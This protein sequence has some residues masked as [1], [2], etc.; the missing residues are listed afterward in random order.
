MRIEAKGDVLLLLA[1]HAM[2]QDT[3]QRASPHDLAHQAARQRPSPYVVTRSGHACGS[4]TASLCIT[5][6]ASRRSSSGNNGRLFINTEL[7]TTAPGAQILVDRWHW[8]YN[9]H[10]LRSTSST[11]R[12]LPSRGVCPW[13][14]LNKERSMTTPTHSHKDWTDKGGYVNLVGKHT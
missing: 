2:V 10:E 7:F 4:D 11:A 13:R 14:Q 3:A 1:A 5:W 6:S 8:E 9:T 12:S